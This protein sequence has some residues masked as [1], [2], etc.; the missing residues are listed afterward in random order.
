MFYKVNTNDLEEVGDD[1]DAARNSIATRADV[2]VVKADYDFE[3]H[4]A[5]FLARAVP[6][7]ILKEACS[8]FIERA[9]SAE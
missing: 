8:S 2:I 4:V 5:D 6:T 1:W 7:T 9:K 3:K